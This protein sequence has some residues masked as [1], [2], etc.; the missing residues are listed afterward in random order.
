MI[1][2]KKMLT[3]ASLYDNTNMDSK[4]VSTYI[5]IIVII[6]ECEIKD[7]DGDAQED[8]IDQQKLVELRAEIQDF[9]KTYLV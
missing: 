7:S 6:I 4:T 8:K 3:F 9:L 2:L 1:Y 5:I